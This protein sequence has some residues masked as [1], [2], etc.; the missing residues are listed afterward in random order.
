[1][2]SFTRVAPT[3]P[4][5][6]LG[7][8]EWVLL[9][10]QEAPDLLG[11]H[12]RVLQLLLDLRQHVHI[13]ALVR[14]V[15]GRVE[16][17]ERDRG[18]PGL[19]DLSQRAKS[20]ERNELS[21]SHLK[22]TLLQPDNYNTNGETF[23]KTAIHKNIRLSLFE[24]RLPLLSFCEMQARACGVPKLADLFEEVVRVAVEAELLHALHEVRLGDVP[25]LLLVE[26]LEEVDGI[27]TCGRR[28]K[29]K[30]D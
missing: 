2:P 28:K 6:R 22:V 1:M 12:P 19:L 11:L 29:K 21:N 3:G 14:A 30:R 7:L 4:G 10:L 5:S 13:P 26:L 25:P 17:R 18:V 23:S 27:P 16:L 15:T 8:R 20:R 24:R 9:A